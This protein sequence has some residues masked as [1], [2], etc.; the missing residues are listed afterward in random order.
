MADP[1]AEAGRHGLRRVS[2]EYDTLAEVYDWLVPEALLEPEG[3]A[4]VFEAVLAEL[5][6]AARVLDCACGT[7]TLAVGLALRGFVVT[8]TDASEGMVAR[9]RALA[10]RHGADLETATRVWEALDGGRSTRPSASATRSRTR[11][12][13]ARRS[14]RCMPCCATTA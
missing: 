7:G 4:A 2:G 1:R 6:S 12:T 5:P 9:T 10:E 11:P 14:A 3:S 8:A 13:A